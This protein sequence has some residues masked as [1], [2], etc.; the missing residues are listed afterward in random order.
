MI[1]KKILYY[2]N[3]KDL[4]SKHLKRQFKIY[5]NERA[6]KNKEKLIKEIRK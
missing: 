6:Y 4:I 2:I 3:N 1:I 5:G